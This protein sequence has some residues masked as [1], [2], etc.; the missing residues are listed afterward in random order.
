[1]SSSA[2]Y[3]S[4]S[5][6]AYDKLWIATQLPYIGL[7]HA[8]RI[9]LD[10]AYGFSYAA[11]IDHRT[12]AA[13]FSLLDASLKCRPLPDGKLNWPMVSQLLVAPHTFIRNLDH[14]GPLANDPLNTLC[15]MDTLAQVFDAAVN[16][17]MQQDLLEDAI[18]QYANVR[19]QAARTM[20]LHLHNLED[21]VVIRAMAHDMVPL[22]DVQYTRDFVISRTFPH[23]ADEDIATI[24][25]PYS[26]CIA[27][28]GLDVEQ[29]STLDCPRYRCPCCLCRQPGHTEQMCSA[30]EAEAHTLPPDV[31]TLADLM[32][33]NIFTP[34]ATR[35]W[36]IVADHLFLASWPIMNHYPTDLTPVYFR[37]K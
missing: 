25:T 15:G 23:L 20:M 6:D 5:L 18:H 12:P 7:N 8:A 32:S 24:A 13:P 36:R 11:A 19:N 9:R 37:T 10:P 21:Q 14:N 2:A 3:D 35:S 26:P 29:H 30:N 31:H 4:L 34:T 1:M 28:L 27:C 33:A 17:Y 16:L 22:R